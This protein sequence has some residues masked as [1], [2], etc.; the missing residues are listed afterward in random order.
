ML[1]KR[2]GINIL[3]RKLISS[4]N[5]ISSC[6]S[7]PKLKIVLKFIIVMIVRHTTLNQTFNN[8]VTIR[9]NTEETLFT[10]APEAT[11]NSVVVVTSSLRTRM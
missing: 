4:L 11:G 9:T 6:F 2:N 10:V 3:K 8:I 7:F 1:L 5:S